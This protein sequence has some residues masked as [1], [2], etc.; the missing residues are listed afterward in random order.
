MPIRIRSLALA[1]GAGIFSVACGGGATPQPTTAK[2]PT[3]PATT[4]SAK[5]EPPPIPVAA[6]EVAKTP[7]TCDAFV[8]DVPAGK[9]KDPSCTDQ[10]SVMATLAAAAAADKKGDQAARDAALNSLSTCEKVPTLVAETVRA[11]LAPIACATPMP[12]R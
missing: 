5:E 3:Q 10:K 2:G 1:M 7:A 6:P 12:G 11:E 8:K 9:P 4:A